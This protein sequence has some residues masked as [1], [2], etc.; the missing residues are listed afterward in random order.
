VR[1]TSPQLKYPPDLF[2]LVKLAC[3]EKLFCVSGVS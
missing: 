3:N 2:G 1:G